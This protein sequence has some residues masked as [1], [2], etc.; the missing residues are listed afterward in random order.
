MPPTGFEPTIPATERPQT[1][2]LDREANDIGVHYELG[3]LNLTIT[4][5]RGL[6]EL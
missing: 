4:K 5:Q 2:P 3:V 6:Y 1:Y